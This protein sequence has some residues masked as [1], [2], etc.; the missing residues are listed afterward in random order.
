MLERIIAKLCLYFG[1]ECGWDYDDLKE[2]CDLTDRE[3]E[4]IKRIVEHVV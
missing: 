2:N 4:I 3:I 1:D